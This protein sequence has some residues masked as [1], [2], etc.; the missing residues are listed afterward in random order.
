MGVWGSK[1]RKGSVRAACEH[2]FVPKLIPAETKEHGRQ[3]RAE[4]YSINRIAALTGMAKSSVSL[5]VRDVPLTAEQEAAFAGASHRKRALGHLRW[6]ESCRQRRREAQLMGRALAELNDPSY[7]AGV[8]LY[9]AEGSKGRNSAKIAN[10]DPDLLR[11]WLDWLE[12]WG[13]LDRAAAALSVNC[14]TDNGLSVEEVEDWWLE[15]L[16][17]PR[18]SLRKTIVNVPS[19]AS[20]GKHKI[21]LHGTAH[22]WVN[23]TFLVQS[24]YGAI[25]EIG[26]FERPEWL[27]LQGA[28]PA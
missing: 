27:D 19:R 11:M 28:L 22:L 16:R 1:Q 13:N 7:T 26:G 2:Q 14:F 6:S 4:G 23:S 3:L 5:L 9:W 25:Q 17:L 8:M 21:L 15:K 18:S 12:E 10:S 20:R 24:I